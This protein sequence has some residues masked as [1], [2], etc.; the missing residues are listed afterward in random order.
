MGSD[1]AIVRLHGSTM[2]E[3]VAGAMRSAGLDVR[4]VGGDRERLEASG[5]SVVDDLYP[6]EGPLGGIITSLASGNDV[7][8]SACDTPL[9]EVEA[10]RHLMSS[11][12]RLPQLQAVI[13]CDWSGLQ[14]LFGLYRASGQEALVRAFGDGA[15]SPRRALR[16]VR[17][18][19]VSS[20]STRALFNVNT[21][22]DLMAAAHLV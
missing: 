19:A 12:A 16:S 2:A 9:V 1:K 15:R 7:L 4:A 14:P 20:R 18:A 10:V 13:S 22:A 8:V 3:R 6:G 5:L 21:P 17:W 11:A